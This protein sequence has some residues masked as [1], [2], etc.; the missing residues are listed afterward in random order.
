MNKPWQDYPVPTMRHEARH[1]DRLVRCFQPRPASVWDLF[2]ASV[3]RTPDAEAVV[4]EGVRLSYAQVDAAVARLAAGFAALGLQA[5]ERVVLFVDNRPEFITVWLAL[6]RLGVI[7][8]P[9]GVR[10]Q[11]PGLAYITRQCGAAAIVADA[12][13]ADRLPDTTEAPEL[14]LRISVGDAPGCLALAALAALAALDSAIPTAAS[15]LPAVAPVSDSE[16]AVI[17]YTSGTTGHPKGATLTHANIV[18]SVLHYQACLQLAIAGQDSPGERAVLAVPASHVTGLVA[19]IATMLHVGG[20]VIVV[21]AFKAETFIALLAD[22][23]ISQTMMVPAMYNL[24]LLHR[25]FAS[26]KLDA[27]RIGGYGGAPMPVATIDALNAQLPGLTLI[28]AYGAT[29]TSSPV[30][31]MPMGRTRE[32]ADTVGVALP[33]ADIRV[34]DDDGV[35]V[36]P[37]ET[38]EL[39]IGGPMVVP[40]YWAIPEATAASFTAGHWHSGDLGSVD[41]QGY[42]RV[43]DRKKDML[44]RGGYKIFSVEVENVL[45]AWPGMVEVAIV[46]R[47]CPVL[48]ERVHA[49]VHMTSGTPDD[50][51]LRAFCAARLADYKVPETITWAAEPL[52]RNANGKLMKRLMRAEL[53]LLPAR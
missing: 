43:F 23:R 20:T 22:E 53:L 6:Q 52:P 42:V 1:G 39:W 25:H 33:A 46:G 36:A 35:E 3:A 49:F 13:L 15:T 50:A 31:M 10:E 48:G 40:G 4:C 14:R 26:A 44:N 38:G 19:I 41:A 30:T 16:V 12:A 9:V 32:H 11:R 51:A 34:M 27:W 28:N 24:C 8:V 17:L 5:G 18:H 21:P 47:P 29:E 37:G 7:T 45:M 2:A